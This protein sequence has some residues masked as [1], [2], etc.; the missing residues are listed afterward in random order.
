MEPADLEII[1]QATAAQDN[2]RPM[3]RALPVF[4]HPDDETIALGARLA[5]GGSA[6]LAA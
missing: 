3:P 5:A 2:T 4:A 1:A 6:C